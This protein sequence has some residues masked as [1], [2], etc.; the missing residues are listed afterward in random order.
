MPGDGGK[1]GSCRVI[2]FLLGALNPLPAT[3]ADH[4]PTRAALSDRN[5]KKKPFEHI[6]LEGLHPACL[7]LWFSS[8]S[9]QFRV[10]ARQLV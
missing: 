5:Q 9:G 6:R 3:E 8:A 10:A 2:P 1:D 4:V 7:T